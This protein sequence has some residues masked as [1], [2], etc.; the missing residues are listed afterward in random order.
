MQEKLLLGLILLCLL[1]VEPFLRT[2]SYQRANANSL[3]STKYKHYLENCI[4]YAVLAGLVLTALHITNFSLTDFGIRSPSFSHFL[5]TSVLFKIALIVISA[6]YFFYYYIITVIMANFGKKVRQQV[7]KK[8][9]AMKYIAPN[10][11]GQKLAWLGY[12]IIMGSAE[13]IIYRGFPFFAA[14]ILFPQTG[15]WFACLL[16]VVLDAWRFMPRYFVI[17]NVIF[18]SL[19][20]SLLFIGFHSLLLL[21]IIHMLQYLKLYLMPFK[22]VFKNEE[23]NSVA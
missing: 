8:L 19:F 1:F 7:V 23:I 21:I 16:A 3:P 5:K 12:A 13:E 20:Y 22:D 15:L 18:T 6:L 10:T 11:P 2:K 9:P 17:A 14:A 4:R